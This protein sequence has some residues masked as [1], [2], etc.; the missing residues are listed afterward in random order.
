MK[1]GFV[2]SM[3]A[4]CKLHSVINTPKEVTYYLNNKEDKQV[5]LGVIG[6]ANLLSRYNVKYADFVK[7]LGLVND[8]RYELATSVNLT[9]AKLAQSLKNA[10]HAAAAVAKRY[11]M[12]R[13][14]TIA[15]CASV[16]YGYT[17]LDGYTT[18]PEIS[19][20][21][22]HPETKTTTRDSGTFGVE[23]YQYPPNVETAQEVG[24]ET[25]FQ[26]ACVWQHLMNSTGLAHCI[27]FNVW[28]EQQVDETFFR[29]W[30]QSPLVTTYY[31]MMVTQDFADKST[32]GVS[33]IS[34]E[35]SA[36]SGFF[37]PEAGD[38]DEDTFDFSFSTQTQPVA[39]GLKPGECTTCAE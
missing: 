5:G 16:S 13:A 38:G 27:S 32:I 12:E 1:K 14:F 8:D 30:L 10:F 20:P 34:M 36:N 29:R 9:G 22:C 21:I 24:F 26:L 25:Y 3:T 19:P 39:C 37:I 18:T 28:D 11:G 17:D 23:E 6:L 33:G 7:C 4:L 31:R 2:D 35:E 15:P